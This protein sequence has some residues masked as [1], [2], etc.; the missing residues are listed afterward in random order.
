MTIEERVAEL[1][2]EAPELSDAECAALG[3]SM[4][5][6]LAGTKRQEAAA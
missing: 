6:V 5:K 4:A 1:L 3:Q 2:A